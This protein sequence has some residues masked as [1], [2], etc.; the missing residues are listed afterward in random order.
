MNNH[1]LAFYA[2]SHG[3]GY[4]TRC[5]AIIEEILETTDNMVYLVSSA[6]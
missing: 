6:I 3:F 4:M 1:Y 5:L 2:S